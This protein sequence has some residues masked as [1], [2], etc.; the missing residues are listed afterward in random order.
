MCRLW[1][2]LKIITTTKGLV[3]YSNLAFNITCNPNKTHQ[4]VGRA[5]G[6]PLCRNMSWL[7]WRNNRATWCTFCS[8][9]AWQQSVSKSIRGPVWHQIS[10]YIFCVCF[11]N[12]EMSMKRSKIASNSCLGTV[13][14]IGTLSFLLPA[15]L[16]CHAFPVLSGHVGFNINLI[17]PLSIGSIAF[18]LI[19]LFYF[20]ESFNDNL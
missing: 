7:K 17:C 14:F 20:F 1:P 6:F 12:I 5:F 4:F 16:T 9:F 13:L 8:P 3:P 15:L 2:I 19:I 11:H 10:N 18:V